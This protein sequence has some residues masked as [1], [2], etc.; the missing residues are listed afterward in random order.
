[1]GKNALRE[2]G[3]DAPIR[4]D[5]RLLRQPPTELYEE[6][7]DASSGKELPLQGGRIL[8]VT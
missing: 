7:V 1:M 4:A 6:I 5:S 8:E 2:A 3:G